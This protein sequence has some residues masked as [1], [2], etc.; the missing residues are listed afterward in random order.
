MNIL[1]KVFLIILIINPIYGQNNTTVNNQNFNVQDKIITSFPKEILS[2]SDVDLAET[3]IKLFNDNLKLNP[4]YSP[5]S[6][7]LLN[8]LKKLILWAEKNENLNTQLNLKY[9]YFGLAYNNK[10]FVE[11]LEIGNELLKYENELSPNEIYGVL[12]CL[13]ACY[14]NLEAYS[15]IIKIIPLRKKYSYVNKTEN[16]LANIEYDLALAYYNNKNYLLSIKSFLIRKQYYKNT[17]GEE[18]FVSSMSNNIGLCYLR[19]KNYPKALEYFNLALSEINSIINIESKRKE[20]GYNI[21]FKA[22]INTNIAKIDIK[23][24]KYLKAI[25]AY[26]NLVQKTKIA[27]EKNNL[28]DGYLNLAKLYFRINKVEVAKKYLDSTKNSNLILA[29]SDTKI[30]YL[31]TKAKIELYNGNIDLSSKLFESSRNTTDSLAL[32]QFGRE[33]ILAQAK[34]N[35]DEKE[36]EL[37]N[38]KID[39]KSK[40]KA[41]RILLIGLAVTSILLSIILFLYFKSI[42][43]KN[44]I[45][46]QKD[47]LVISLTEKEILLKELHHRVKNNL[48]VIIGL[49]QL[50]SKKVKSPEMSDLLNDS[51]RYIN[52]MSLVHEMLYQQDKIEVVPM[53]DYLK[54]LSNQILQSFYDKKITIEINAD[55]IELPINKAIPLGLM[56]S[57]LMTNSN[58]YAFKNNIGTISINLTNK[59]ENKLVFIYQDSGEGL[60]K[61]FEEKIS[62]TMGL[63]LLKMLSDEINGTIE[64]TNK[65]GFNA[66]LEFTTHEKI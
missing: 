38:A 53:N 62:K 43:D 56:V 63:R 55:G 61:D 37:T 9:F 8:P 45:K 65:N 52:S 2:K 11:S 25:I 33:N 29:A 35:N 13:N 15:E 60:P 21:F 14:R 26:N 7:E 6:V 46:S 19:L 1:I 24:G 41:S 54:K 20:K 40:E 5:N 17:K 22:I 39:I 59:L 42:K 51:Q 12:I 4:K 44:T 47:T 30:D 64:L 32:V 28:T 3:K 49:L 18:L 16:E 31:N 10:K 36:K 57:E 23:N 48:Q 66:T 58:K 27:G 34:Y 50:Q